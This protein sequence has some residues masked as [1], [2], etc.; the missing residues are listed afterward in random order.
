MLK[1]RRIYFSTKV[2]S[3]SVN[4]LDGEKSLS[5]PVQEEDVISLYDALNT[6]IQSN[7][8]PLKL[9][10]NYFDKLKH[11]FED[12]SNQK[13]QN[14]EKKI[15]FGKMNSIPSLEKISQVIHVNAK[16][17][18]PAEAQ[19]AFDS[20]VLLGLKPD[21]IAYN[22]LMAAYAKV[23]RPNDV[24]DIMNTMKKN[25]IAP[26][27]ISYSTLISAH[28]KNEDLNSAFDVYEQMKKDGQR[29]NQIVYSTLIKGCIVKKQF[30]RAWKTFNHFREHEQPDGIAYSIM[31]RVCSYTK[32]AERAL[33]LFEEMASYN[34]PTNRDTYNSV[35]KACGSRP[36]YYNDAFNLMEQMILNG[37]ELNSESYSILFEIVAENGDIERA[38]LLWNDLAT[39]IDFKKTNDKSVVYANPPLLLKPYMISNLFKLY[40]KVLVE[41][42]LEKKMMVN[43]SKV[44]V[45]ETIDTEIIQNVSLEPIPDTQLPLN[46]E[47]GL[48]RDSI[49]KEADWTWE[50]CVKLVKEKKLDM[51][52]ILLNRRLEQLCAIGTDKSL[53]DA[54]NFLQTQF[55][56]YNIPIKGSSYLNLLKTAWK[57]G[58]SEIAEEIWKQFLDWDQ[59]LELKLTEAC[60]LIPQTLPQ[61]EATRYENGRTA[62]AMSEAFLVVAKGYSKSGNLDRAI[63][64]LKQA[65]EFRYPYY[66]MPVQT[67]HIR[68]I[69]ELAIREADFGNLIP[70][71]E[72]EKLCLKPLPDP[73]EMARNQLKTKYIPSSWWGWEA[74]GYDAAGKHAL[75]R[76]QKKE[77]AKIIQREME[78]RNKGMKSKKNHEKLKLF[79]PLI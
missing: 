19:K 8:S 34:I 9:S 24:V 12:I 18:R 76:K 68:D 69:M 49:I 65:R 6:P 60:K 67:N 32:D 35:I 59:E 13:Y 62:R 23:A 14:L 27:M 58:K 26:D 28:V 16:T 38:R 79:K 36:D 7:N 64:V 3:K 46:E 11:E 10:K 20:I 39:R 31:I 17:N 42:F 25:G 57:N 63:K 4:L 54:F 45:P 29:P 74:M 44:M 78:L 2:P 48:S 22:H 30:D 51:N 37:F 66:L 72:L 40:S 75:V 55:P 43:D 15:E 47:T 1:F 33:D 73:L 21:V 50:L 77:N 5:V 53:S 61:K 71:K 70:L 41:G 56:N 52:G